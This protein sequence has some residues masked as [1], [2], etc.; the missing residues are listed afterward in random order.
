MKLKITPPKAL[1]VYE[2]AD[3]ITQLKARFIYY[4]ILSAMIILGLMIP[5][6]SVLQVSTSLYNP[7]NFLVITPM[8]LGMMVFAGC[9]R[10]LTKGRYA[11]AAHLLLISSLVLVWFI[12]FVSRDP[13]LG[14]LGTV[15]WLFAI[16]AMAPLLI[17]SKKWLS[18]AYTL[19]NALVFVVFLFVIKDSLIISKYE[20][21]DFLV[22]TTIAMIFMGAIS[23][24]VFSITKAAI[25]KAKSDIQQRI[26][27]E[28]AL[29]ESEAKY[30]NLFDT[31]PNGF[32]RST[33]EGYF[34]DAN[35]AFVK[36]LG[37]S[38]FEEL[39]SV[40]IPRDLYIH[41]AERE[42]ITLTSEFSPELVTYRLK[43]KDGSIIWLE[44][45]AR[46]IK[47]EKGKI[48]F[49][50]GICRDVSDRKKAEDALQESEAD[51]K[52]IIENSMDSIWS[53]NRDYEIKYVNN[54]FVG[55]FENVFGVKIAK[56]DSL[57]EALP[58]VI[59]GVWKERYDKIFANEN[60]VFEDVVEH[61]GQKVY[62][63]VSGNPIAMEGTVTG[64][65]FFG[66]NITAKK[67]AGEELRQSK[68]M[69]ET[70][71]EVAPIDISLS[72]EQGRYMLVNNTLAQKL[73]QPAESILGKTPREAGMIIDEQ[74]LQ[75][76][77]QQLETNGI[78][79]GLE[80]ISINKDG[81]VNYSYY[82]G[83][84]ITIN[85]AH[86]LL[87]TSLEITEKKKIEQELQ[88]HKNQLESLVQER[89]EELVAANEE[90]KATNDQLF[91]K[92]KIIS[93]QKEELEK[94]LSS[95]QE[96]QLK[97]I[98]SEKMASL[99]I[100]TAGVAHEINNPINFIANGTTAIESFI[101][102]QHAESVGELSPLF[103]AIR[104][105]VKRVTGIIRSMSKYNRSEALPASQCNIHEIIDDG[106]TLLYNQYKTR[107]NIT[108][109]YNAVNSVVE[110]HEGQLHQVF[111]NIMANAIQAIENEGEIT[112]ET[113]NP[114]N[115][116]RII[117]TD[118]GVGISPQ[119]IM[120]IFDPFYTTKA[121]GKGT[122]LG[123]SISQR[124]I[125]DHNG[126]IYCQSTLK[127]GSSFIVELPLSHK[128]MVK[129]GVKILY[130]DDEPN[131]LVLFARLFNRRFIV[132]QASSGQ[133]GLKV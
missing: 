45:N 71:F 21:A 124:I 132:L 96:L 52:A 13:D 36:M 66:K 60:F 90:L 75:E 53:L 91:D 27:S 80:L 17:D 77:E 43:R 62:I 7:V 121:P 72:D 14:R 65:C 10:L 103:E 94:T 18:L 49:H 111:L 39:K 34:V 89:T 79:K 30:K 19:I 125:S 31:M 69:F 92:N 48:I 133:E 112:I 44:E 115:V 6:I 74:S 42:K 98:Q 73:G 35:P 109:R 2:N 24:N 46:F 93:M 50:E 113:S 116:V 63:E 130:V 117:I 106:L 100:L 38:S 9:Y 76:L 68:E 25:E 114:G 29:R 86:C 84:R 104:E 99:G 85:G 108:R 70:L 122:G 126:T 101:H 120:H 88:D 40:Y 64:A 67:L 102:E 41:E 127:K 51:L 107:I 47:D 95:L 82:N 32:Y 54:V 20:F 110:A 57:L 11:I 12:M 26:Q 56:G 33:P 78:V 8:I 5:V 22:N 81:K 23:Y 3:F 55:E 58:E 4:L 61:D 87:G 131:N 59:R 123:L 28:K 97:L 15:V 118:T 16:L 128:G 37:Y 119:Q 105:G 83:T 129:E 1:E